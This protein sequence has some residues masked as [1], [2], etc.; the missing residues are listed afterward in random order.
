MEPKIKIIIDKKRIRPKLSEIDRLVCDNSLILKKTL[1][2]PLY[3]FDKGLNKTIDWIKINKKMIFAD[4][5]H[6]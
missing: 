4:N 6:V 2:K 5:Y 1:W 3:S